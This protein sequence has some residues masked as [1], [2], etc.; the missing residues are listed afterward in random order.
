MVQLLHELEVSALQ[1]FGHEPVELGVHLGC[2]V[3]LPISRLPLPDEAASILALVS[4]VFLEL[5]VNEWVVL[6]VVEVQVARQLVHLFVRVGLAQKLG[7]RRIC[8]FRSRFM[9]S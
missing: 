7:H 3:V 5:A 9:S 1:S 8:D 2:K 6:E 4:K